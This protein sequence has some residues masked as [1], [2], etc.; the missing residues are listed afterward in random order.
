MNDKKKLLFVCYGLGI[1]GIERCLINL[2]NAIDTTKYSI[3]VLPMNPIYDLADYLNA[4]CTV[5]DPFEYAMNTTDTF[6]E[7]KKR[8]AGPIVFLRYVIFRVL[9]KYKIRPWKIFRGPYKHYDIAIAYANIAYVPYYVIDRVN[10]DYKYLWYHYGRYF[11]GNKY[12][13]DQKY[14][15]KFDAII[16]VS[17][18]S[19]RELNQV[20][21]EIRKKTIVIHN[22]IDSKEI[23]RKALEQA[24]VIFSP[25][26][27]NIVTV[28]RLCPEKNPK[29]MVQIAELLRKEGLDFCWYWVGGGKLENQISELVQSNGL[30]EHVRL[31]GNKENPYPYMYNCDIY[32]QPSE[33]EA[34]CTTTLE[35]MVLA[36][37]II[38]TDVGGMREQ[39]VSGEDCIMTA[40]DVNELFQAVLFLARHPEERQRLRYNLYN[41]NDK[42]NN[43]LQ[44]HYDLFN[45]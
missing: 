41:K 36:K 31:L 28:G 22:V 24:D 7:I 26:K 29:Y 27:I 18:D 4:D 11:K 19:R 35:A 2:L 1:G 17:K 6:S 25:Q 13:L 14:Y 23:K 3:D 34:Y 21:P 38:V 5:L 9:N 39:F 20:F 15:P 43:D 10:A 33:F 32:V 37:P 30:S 45:I 8:K 44:C 12:K 16:T 40:V 42:E